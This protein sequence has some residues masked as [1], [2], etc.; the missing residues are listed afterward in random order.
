MGPTRLTNPQSNALQREWI[1]EKILCSGSLCCDHKTCFKRNGTE[2]AQGHCC[3]TNTCRL[4]P[5]GSVCRRRSNE[6]DK[7]D[8][9]NGKSATCTADN[10][11]PNGIPCHANKGVCSNGTCLSLDLQCQS[12]WE[13]APGR[14]VTSMNTAFL[15]DCKLYNSHH[16]Y[17]FRYDCSDILCGDL[18]CGGFKVARRSYKPRPDAKN[19]DFRY[20]IKSMFTK[21]G[22]AITISEP[23]SLRHVIEGTWCGNNKVCRN[24]R[25]KKLSD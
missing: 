9:C 20:V 4:K 3:D 24:R 8:R 5:S 2:C 15:Q 14:T 17:G 19:R 10:Y 23:G 13:P 6:C 7:T 16:P 11:R 12:L 21:F 22:T 18:L 25:C 1:N